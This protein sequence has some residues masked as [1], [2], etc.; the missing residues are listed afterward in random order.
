MLFNAL[1]GFYSLL[2]EGLL[3]GIVVES[4]AEVTHICPVYN[5]FSLPRLTRRF[6]I[7]GKNITDY[8]IKVHVYSSSF[9]SFIYIF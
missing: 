5:G 8:L 7:A 6:D 4:G 9:I 2:H 1:H 3:T